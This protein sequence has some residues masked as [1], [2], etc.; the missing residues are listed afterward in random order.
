MENSL[1]N[2]K[3]PIAM[4]VHAVYLRKTITKPL[5]KNVIFKS[6]NIKK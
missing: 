2:Y 3:S 4:L 1:Y 6:R 5:L